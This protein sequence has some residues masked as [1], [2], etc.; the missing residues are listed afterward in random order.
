MPKKINKPQ[1]RHKKM[2]KREKIKIIFNRIPKITTIHK[3][4]Y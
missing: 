1:K 3:K 4:V 2:R